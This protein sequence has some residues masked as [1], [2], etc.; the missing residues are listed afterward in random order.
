[1]E[2][3]TAKNALINVNQLC[4]RYGVTR[5]FIRMASRDLGFPAPL[6]LG[7]I[8]FYISEEIDKWIESLPR[9]SGRR[10]R[11]ARLDEGQRNYIAA[12]KNKRA[13]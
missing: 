12:R 5:Y 1:M 13:A 7:K 10:A 11:D 8:N 9:R 4:E 6:K 2:I 3:K